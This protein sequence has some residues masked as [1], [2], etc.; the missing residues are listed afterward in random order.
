M[1]G[2]PAD[3]YIGYNSSNMLTDYKTTE[4]K[5]LYIDT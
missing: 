2:D 4:G 5:I 3:D 1:K